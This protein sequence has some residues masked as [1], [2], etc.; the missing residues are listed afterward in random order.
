MLI[1]CLPTDSISN[2]Q[3]A[4]VENIQPTLVLQ[5]ETATPALLVSTVTSRP[6]PIP[7]I[8]ISPPSLTSIEPTIVIDTITPTP[9]Y[10]I[11]RAF[12]FGGKR[13]AISPDK[14][15]IAVASLD[16]NTIH[17]YS[18]ETGQEQYAL[19]KPTA[20]YHRPTFSILAFSPDSRYLAVS[21]RE[22]TVWVW[23]IASGDLVSEFPFFG[24]AIDITFSP[25]GSLLAISSASEDLEEHGVGIFDVY[26]GATISE[27]KNI[28][29]TSAVFLKNGEQLLVGADL[30]YPSNAERSNGLFI[31]D[32][33]VDTVS[34]VL[35]QNSGGAW[36]I[37][38]DNEGKTLITIIDGTLHSIEIQTLAE[39]EIENPEIRARNLHFD[40]AGNIWALDSHG[41]FF[42]WDADGKFIRQQQFDNAIDFVIVPKTNQLLIVFPEETWEVTFFG[43]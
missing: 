3:T 22:F 40:D 8:T 5:H 38:V 14:S 10:Q 18:Y 21:G 7:S 33:K 31:W 2:E 39:N 43:T 42:Q 24:I 35:S 25:D 16:G 32:Y 15:Q 19:V 26:T 1:G 4:F 30:F 17:I 34:N 9:N 12:N 20:P 36:D 41:T 11:E 37:T 29:A 23:D 13:L 28:V 27:M 6:S